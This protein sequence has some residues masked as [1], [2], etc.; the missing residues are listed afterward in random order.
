MND[1]S[2]QPTYIKY[3]LIYGVVSLIYAFALFSSGLVTNPAMSVVSIAIGFGI[4]FLAIREYRKLNGGYLRLKQG[5]M[6]G[7]WVGLIAA[8]VSGLFSMLYNTLINP[9]FIPNLIDTLQAQMEESGA[10]PEAIE[11]SLKMYKFMFAPVPSLVVGLLSGIGG[12]ALYGLIA[13]A[14]MKNERPVMEE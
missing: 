7:L 14:I 6:I 3:G 5:V 8:V 10:P 11:M 1:L 12:G 13:G 2:I 9:D 4:I